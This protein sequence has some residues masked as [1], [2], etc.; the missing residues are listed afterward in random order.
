[1]F[2]KK[3]QKREFGY[4]PVHS[5]MTKNDT[6]LRERIKFTTFSSQD[7]RSSK[8]RTIILILFL[9]LIIAVIV[10]FGISTLS[11][12]EIKIKETEFEKITP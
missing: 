6:P 4:R 9:I 8:R 3:V 7:K 2:G 12:E 5:D 10:N 1:M 11:I